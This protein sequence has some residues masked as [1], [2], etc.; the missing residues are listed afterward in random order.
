VTRK[1]VDSWRESPASPFKLP[2]WVWWTAAAVVA[3]LTHTL[4]DMHIGLW[5]ETSQDMTFLQALNALSIG[6]V[7]AGWFLVVIRGIRGERWAMRA[8]FLYTSVFAFLLHGLVAFVAAPPPSA[9]FPYQDLAHSLSLIFGGIASL[10][11]WNSI[12][13]AIVKGRAYDFA[14]AL[15]VIVM[16]Q[17]VGG[18]IFFQTL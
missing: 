9:A 5:G 13:G 7:Y 12:N 1:A 3:T 18:I 14:G 8:A 10:T 17:A 6:I 2:G 4:I 15:I 16:S 11:I